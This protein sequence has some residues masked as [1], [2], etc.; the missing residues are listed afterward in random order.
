MEAQYI[1][2]NLVFISAGVVIGTTR[3]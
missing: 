1:V 3:R 2:K